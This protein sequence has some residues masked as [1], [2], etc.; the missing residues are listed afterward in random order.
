MRSLLAIAAAV[1]LAG[2]IGTAVYAMIQDDPDPAPV[3]TNRQ[4]DEQDAGAPSGGDGGVAAICLEGATD[5]DDTIDSG[6]AGGACLE[7]ATECS[8]DP[9]FQ[10]CATEEPCGDFDDRCAADGPG[11]FAPMPATELACPEGMTVEECFEGGVPAGFECV[12]LESFP[13]QVKCYPVECMPIDGGSPGDSAPGDDGPVTIL[14]APA[15]PDAPIDEPHVDPA[16]PIEIEP[17]PPTQACLPGD[18]AEDSD[19]VMYCKPVDDPCS[20]EPDPNVRCLPPHCSVSSD[21]SVD[22]PVPL[23]EPCSLPGDA[24]SEF[25]QCETPPGSGGGSGGCAPELTAEE[26]VRTDPPVQGGGSS[27]GSPGAE[28]TEIAIE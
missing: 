11:C 18:C 3:S 13:V 19:G 4:S 14:P 15:D 21:G 28:A 17:V 6:A 23:P 2:T 22:C 26:C 16:P 27:E 1:V 5:C 10:Q 9:G 24:P 7:G 20:P 12:T 25:P 8:D